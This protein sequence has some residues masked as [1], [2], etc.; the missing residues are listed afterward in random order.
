MCW[1]K[2]VI[3]CLLICSCSLASAIA[4]ADIKAGS[5]DLVFTWEGSARKGTIT[6][7]QDGYLKFS[8]DLPDGVGQAEV[9][10]PRQQV[11]R[12]SL[13]QSKSEQQALENND[14]EQLAKIWSAR[15]QYLVLE[16]SDSG[17]FGLAY[18]ECLLERAADGDVDAA[19]EIFSDIEAND[20]NIE[21]RA[22]ANNGKL[23]S[24]IASGM[25][26]EAVEQARELAEQSEDPEVLIEAKYVL[27]TAAREQ[28]DQL[29]EENPRWQEDQWVRPERYRLYH[30]ALNYYLFPYLFHGTYAKP[31]ARGLWGAIE[32]YLQAG[33]EELAA[34]TA[35]DLLVLYGDTEHAKRAAELLEVAAEN[36]TQ[37]GA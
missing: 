1:V 18:A 37:E 11:K 10:V 8:V 25:A 9:S 15:K 35:R 23:R 30:E 17:Q 32:V 27:A 36:P 22:L 12:I 28:L 19:I 16:K 31:A 5:E 13:A 20:W 7:F 3:I 4:Q 33:E 2:A 6:G 29:L 14:L 21:R 26:G 24:M 34:E